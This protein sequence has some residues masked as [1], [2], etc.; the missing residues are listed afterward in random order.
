MVSISL[1][2]ESGY[3]FLVAAGTA[4]L[5]MYQMLKVRTGFP[6]IK[7]EMTVFS[8]WRSKEEIRSSVSSNVQRQAARVQ[9]LSGDG[10]QCEKNNL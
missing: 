6:L 8:G 7:P 10:V 5:N 4:L 3:V 1:Q 9:L 2:P